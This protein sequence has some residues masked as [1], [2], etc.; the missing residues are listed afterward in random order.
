MI[1]HWPSEKA[2]SLLITGILLKTEEC[3]HIIDVD[4]ETV[5]ARLAPTCLID[6]LPGDTVL[7]FRSNDNDDVATIISIL[8]RREMPR[9]TISFPEGVDLHVKGKP[10]HVTAEEGFILDASES[11]LTTKIL[12]VSASRTS[13]LLNTLSAIADSIDFLSNKLE[14]CSKWI[15]TQTINATKE[16]QGI[17]HT[18]SGQTIVET[19]SLYSVSSA[20][21]VISAQD[22]VKI[23][24]SQ[25]HLG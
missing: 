23:D 3:R 20:T 17:D 14:I 2:S 13:L 12:H 22:L 11:V 1:T 9:P 7:A 25:I 5:L 21:T 18:K 15:R 16:I 24:S 8:E 6:L 10:F 4:G 19:D